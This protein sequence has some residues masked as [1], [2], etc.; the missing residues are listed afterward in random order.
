MER[1]RDPGPAAAARLDPRAST[2]AMRNAR[3]SSSS[4][5]AA[6]SRHVSDSS[7]QPA[8]VLLAK[9]AFKSSRR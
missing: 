9:S 6:G 8:S 4:V 5:R 1:H 2:R 7:A 3:V